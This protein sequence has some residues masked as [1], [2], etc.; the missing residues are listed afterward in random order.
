MSRF[1][2]LQFTIVCFLICAIA[3]IP[4]W[5]IAPQG[6]TPQTSNFDLAFAGFVGVTVGAMGGTAFEFVLKLL[7]A[8][9]YAKL[10]LKRPLTVLSFFNDSEEVIGLSAKFTDGKK[11]LKLTFE[12]DEVGR[13]FEVLNL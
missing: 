8:P 2:R 7:F 5:L 1:F 4:A 9:A 10:L 6:T 11:S 3:A 13:E 12:N